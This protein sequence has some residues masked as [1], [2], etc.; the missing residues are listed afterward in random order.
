MA[1]PNHRRDIEELVHQ[2]AQADDQK[3]VLA[4][5]FAPDEQSDDV[6]LL[7]V[8]DGFGFN[9]PSIDRELMETMYTAKAGFPLPQDALL[10]LVLT[11][12]A[13]LSIALRDRWSSAQPLINAVRA[14]RFEFIYGDEVGRRLLDQ[15][16]S[17]P[18]AA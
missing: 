5:Y 17:S 16:A 1:F 3:I 9:E 14:G 4:V 7:E 18:V 11:S 8:V 6:Y 15:V 10:H 2:H 12:P 13:E